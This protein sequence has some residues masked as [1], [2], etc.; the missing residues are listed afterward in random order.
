[1]ASMSA[2]RGLPRFLFEGDTD[3]SDRGSVFDTKFSS[4]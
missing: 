2:L 1:L 3:T 4:I